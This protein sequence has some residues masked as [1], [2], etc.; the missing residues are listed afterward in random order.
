M[1]NITTSELAS[2]M[3]LLN[4]NQI[5]MLISSK[6]LS[7]SQ[8][9]QA[10]IEAGISREE[11]I[12]ILTK[13]GLI[14][15]T[16]GQTAANVG[17]TASLKG[18]AAGLWATTKAF[19]AS[20][21]GMAVIAAGAIFAIV[22]AVDWLTVS[23]EES[24]ENLSNLKQEYSDNENKL[25]SLNSELETTTKR[26]DELEKKDKLT[27]TEQNELNNLK[28]QNAEL[29]REIH[30]LEQEQK[31]K[32]R[33]INLSMPLVQAMFGEMEEF[34]GEFDWSDEAS[35]SIGDLGVAA[36]ESAEKLRALKGNED[37]KIQMDVEG[38]EDA[39][40]KVEV[41]DGTIK[42]M[43]ELKA[44]PGVDSSQ[45]EH[46]NNVIDYCIAQKQNIEKPIVMNVNTSKLD[47]KTADAISKIQQFK[48]AAN[49]VQQL[50][51]KGLDTTKAQ[52]E[53]DSLA[54]DI[55][56]IDPTIQTALKL[57]TFL[58]GNIS[59]GSALF[60]S[61]LCGSFCCNL[62]SACFFLCNL[63]GSIC[64]YLTNICI[65]FGF[66][67]SLLLF[68]FSS[69][70][71]Y[72]FFFHCRKISL[73]LFNNLDT[74]LLLSNFLLPNC[75]LQFACDCSIGIRLGCFK[76]GKQNH[77]YNHYYRCSR[78]KHS[79]AFFHQ[80]FADCRSTGSCQSSCHTE[81]THTLGKSRFGNN[82]RCDC[83]G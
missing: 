53:V 71:N 9:S 61:F 26:I 19:L 12:Q 44:K 37:L 28:R 59:N 10:L 76:A 39:D 69:C 77:R 32:S 21:L 63:N 65:G 6:E 13:A 46:A 17:L 35:K 79:K 51:L 48:N 27:F 43:Q 52:K 3:K 45:I 70:S 73:F 41:L 54:E 22:K 20:P 36:N 38:I 80:R 55:K 29:E 49:K 16:E 83:G 15:A 64:T 81:H 31:I 75:S 47:S 60:T 23:L 50:K 74:T 82:I 25:T 56:D 30:L 24:R 57:D 34:G 78:E 62:G 58:L 42:E 33:E 68:S 7:V 40:E 1:V 14:T 66:N 2:T 72:F 5:V 67:L 8:A 4:N 11:R 18:V